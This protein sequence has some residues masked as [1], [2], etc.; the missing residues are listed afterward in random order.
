[1]TASPARRREA[2]VLAALVVL[3]LLP[4]LD[5]AVSIDAP[6]F[7]A[8]AERIAQ[9]PG[10]P[11]GFDMVWDP[12]SPHVYDFNRNPP[13]VSYWLAPWIAVFGPREWV[14]HLALLPFPLIAGLSL[15]GIAR[16]WT[17]DPLGP[18][19]LLVTSP[20]FL[21][22]ASTLLLDVPLVACM[23]LAVYALARGVE[24]GSE[25]WQ[26]AAGGAAAAAGLVKY[27]GFSTAPLLAAGVLLLARRRRRALV[28]VLLPPCL[29][30]AA[31]GAYTSEMYGSVHFLGSS[32]LLVT[33]LFARGVDPHKFWNQLVSTPVFYGGALVFPLA[34]W[35][36]LLVRGPRGAE[37]ALAC[38]LLG[39]GAVYAALPHGEPPRW[40]PMPPDQLV[41]ASLSAAAAAALWISAAS[42]GWRRGGPVDRLLL[43]WLAGL[44]VFTALLN[45][46][47]NAA[48]ALLAAPPVLLLLHRTPALRP[49]RRFTGLTAGLTLVL[50]LALAWADAIQNDIYRSAA[51]S[52]AAEI[53]DKPGGRWVVGNW[54]LQYYLGLEGFRPVAPPQYGR[55]RLGLSPEQ[56]RSDLA[57]G[58]WLAT[59]R[60]V[61][62]LDVSAPMERY[63]RTVVW[64][65][66]QTSWLP[67]RTTN[68]DA[69]A[70]FY[71]H[72]YGYVPF[73][74]S[75]EP[76]ERVVL[77]RVVGVRR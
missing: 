69:S 67:L 47:V 26:W 12:T 31:W 36:R 51:R 49:G 66:E 40:H 34:V 43:L 10:D 50:S 32:H 74:F 8:V 14:M 70:G 22:L 59:A 61:S 45:W 44:F 35:G 18:A 57:L 63:R 6:V 23:L 9:A 62:Q 19:A 72:H 39:A 28:R 76:F 17:D 52:I 30:W 65:W 13:L 33:K 3:P 24:E 46:H 5:A 7:I 75:R 27:V 41:F 20:A 16:R 77:G 71:S 60:N 73:G 56:R 4:F 15:L 38:L 68:P 48:D 29:A 54:G 58:D 25:A 55:R 2:L 42:G 11:Y 1:M 37:V 64:V 21:V 53:G